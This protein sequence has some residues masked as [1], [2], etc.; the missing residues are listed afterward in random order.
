MVLTTAALD[1]MATDHLNT[2][3]DPNCQDAQD[4]AAE[5]RGGCG[6]FL[7]NNG[8]VTSEELSKFEIIEYSSQVV[9][10]KI[11]RV[12]VRSHLMGL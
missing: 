9:A 3:G 7:H 6:F 12:T 5:L 11:H 1:I 2:G 4:I 8:K 10:G